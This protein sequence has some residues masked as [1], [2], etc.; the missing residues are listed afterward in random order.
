MTF[1]LRNIL[2]PTDS[3]KQRGDMNR[4]E[5]KEFLQATAWLRPLT[6]WAAAFAFKTDGVLPAPIRNMPLKLVKLILAR[7]HKKTGSGGKSC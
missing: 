3:S 6:R 5:Q 4:A 1:G 7:Q 2:Q